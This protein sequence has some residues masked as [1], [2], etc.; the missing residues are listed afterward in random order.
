MYSHEIQRLLGHKNIAIG[1][2]VLVQKDGKKHEGLLMPKPSHGD[3]RTV[4]IKLDSGYNVGFDIT[5]LVISKAHSKEPKDVKEEAKY[6]FGRTNKELLEL[7]FDA[8]KPKVAL[9]STGG[10]IA[11]RVDYRTGG[12]YAVENPKE[13]LHNIPELSHIVNLEMFSPIKKMRTG[14]TSPGKS[15]RS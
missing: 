8:N 4:L 9:I 10:T 11:S 3:E 13:L 5:G 14:N 6:E 7:K 15:P 1:D 2:R 12:V